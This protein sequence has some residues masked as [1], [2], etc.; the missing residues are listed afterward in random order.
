[1]VIVWADT[2]EILDIG[3]LA[4]EGVLEDSEEHVGNIDK[5]I[6][7]EH[8]LPEVPRITHL[9]HEIKEEHGSTISIDN[10]IETLISA[11]ETNATRGI[12]SWWTTSKRS[13]SSSHHME[14][15]AV[16]SC[17]TSPNKLGASRWHSHQWL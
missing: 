17:Q 2:L 14:N 11:R 8:T 10:S 13:E 7:A 3:V 9:G 4:L 16:H 6:G 12:A 15:L 1:L 5:Y